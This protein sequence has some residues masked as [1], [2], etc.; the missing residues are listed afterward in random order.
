MQSEMNLYLK[1]I[2]VLIFCQINKN[3]SVGTI[4][5]LCAKPRTSSMH[6]RAIVRKSAR[7]PVRRKFEPSDKYY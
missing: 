1:R 5:P 3:T 4:L 6:N 2:I 7:K